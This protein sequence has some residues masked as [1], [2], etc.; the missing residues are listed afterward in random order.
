MPVSK[1]RI[2]RR[3]KIARRNKQDVKALAIMK[4][5]SKDQKA[6][7][8]FYLENGYT[9]EILADLEKQYIARYRTIYQQKSF[10]SFLIDNHKEK[11]LKLSI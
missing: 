2:K 8:A 3:K 7:L 6:A 10:L 11:N 9:K 4:N 1:Q 5:R